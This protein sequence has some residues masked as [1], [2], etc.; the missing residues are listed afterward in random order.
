MILKKD[1]E[2]TFKEGFRL[3]QRITRASVLYA[4]AGDAKRLGDEVMAKFYLESAKQWVDMS[5]NC[6]RKFT[7][8]VAH[9]PD[10]PMFDFGDC[11]QIIRPN[12]YAEPS[13]VEEPNLK[14]VNRR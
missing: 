14:E 4:Q 10:Q 3:G 2:A 13:E 11:E 9:D 8:A 12:D 1:Y 5:K 6:G 7:P